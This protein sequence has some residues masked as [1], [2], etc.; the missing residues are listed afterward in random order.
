MKTTGV[1][2]LP[3][4]SISRW[5][6]GRRIAVKQRRVVRENTSV[7][8]EIS[9]AL[10]ETIRP[11]I[12]ALARYGG[13]HTM[14]LPSTEISEN[15]ALTETDKNIQ[16]KKESAPLYFILDHGKEGHTVTITTAIP[17]LKHDVLLGLK[18]DYI[19]IDETTVDVNDLCKLVD[20]QY[21]LQHGD[22]PMENLQKTN[23]GIS[24]KVMELMQPIRSQASVKLL[25]Y[26]QKNGN[27]YAENA[28]LSAEYAKTLSYRMNNS[29][30]SNA[31]ELGI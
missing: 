24:A 14:V 2:T 31:Y 27:V 21:A 9:P 7:S 28:K 26:I 16:S 4:N 20:N 6:T 18:K 15:V 30:T 29:D 10:K 17:Q 22:N 5:L 3:K 19:P 11:L 1:I 13:S 12:G 23:I 8:R 25:K